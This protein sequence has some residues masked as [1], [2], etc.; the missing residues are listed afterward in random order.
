M[1]VKP[2]LQATAGSLEELERVIRAGA[3]AVVI[4]EE[5]FGICLPGSFDVRDVRQAV[6]F[7]HAHH[8]KLYVAADGIFT[9]ERSD[10]FPEYIREIAACGADALL[11]GD[12]A[13]VASRRETGISL[14]LHWNGEMLSTNYETANYWG[15][16]GATRVL[17]SRELN[18]EEALAF[19]QHCLLEV[20]IQVHGA[21]RIYH[22]KRPL[23]SH[24]REHQ[25]KTYA[26]EAIGVERGLYLIEYERKDERFPVYE[27]L[28]GTHIMSSEDLCMLENL[29]E[30]M[31]GGF[32]SFKIEGLLKSMEYNE[33]VVN[34]YRKAM[35]A[36]LLNSKCWYN[37]DW[38][39][40]IEEIQP[41][42]RPLS[43]GFFYK[44]Q[45]Y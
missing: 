39:K 4:G 36:Y 16:R 6:Q 41:E 2:E 18:M 43:Y 38:L 15:R 22:S 20:Q 37:P 31:T 10:E 12:P 45:V 7:T 33:T 27:D 3:D 9:N 24:Y 32:D 30:L 13:V 44:E 25:G 23:V 19:K 28:N 21:T 26:D 11:F 42:G 5:K 34:I 1:G 17:L 8:A 14:P 29:D 40:S 35:D